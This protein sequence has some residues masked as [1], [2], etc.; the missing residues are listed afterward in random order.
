MSTLAPS[1]QAYFTERLIGQ[2][3]ASP[4]TIAAYKLTFRLLLGF[5]SKVTGKAPSRLDIADLDAPLVASFPDHLEQDRH[6]QRRDPE[7]PPGGSAFAVRLPRPATSRARRHHR[8]RAGGPPETDRAQP[9]HLPHRHRGRSGA[10]SRSLA[11]SVLE[12]SH[13]APTTG[14]ET[15]TD[16]GRM[17][18]G[19]GE[20]ARTVVTGPLAPYARGWRAELAAR[21]YAPHSITAHAQLMAH[22]SG[23]L[24]AAGYGVDAL[25]DE[26]VQKYCVARRTAGYQNRTTARAVAPLL[27]YLRGLR[28]ALPPVEPVP[29]TS[30]EMVISDFCDYL[31]SEQGLAAGTVQP[32]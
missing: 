5:A 11:V 31:A 28:V 20:P 23:W 32:G 1:L 2:R 19:R 12:L 8:T 30:A 26:V 13:S 9:R 10:R 17:G 3:A 27:G 21:G 25:T 14:D 6:K 18:P 15:F 7:Q 29:A 24:A 22:L 4:N 16:T